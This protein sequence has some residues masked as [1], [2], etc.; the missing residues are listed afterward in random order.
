ML[1]N[2]SGSD[3]VPWSKCHTAMYLIE[4]LCIRKEQWEIER[5]LS[6]KAGYLNEGTCI[7]PRSNDNN[8]S[9][10]KARRRDLK[11]DLMLLVVLYACM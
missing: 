10:K 6:W 5:I 7:W 8:E 3:N 9:T 4:R 2:Y 1:S 11:Q